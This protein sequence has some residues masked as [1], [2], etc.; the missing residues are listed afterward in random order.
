MRN[1][2]NVIFFIITC[3]LLQA[4]VAGCAMGSASASYRMQTGNNSVDTSSQTQPTANF[5]DTLR[6]KYTRQAI[7]VK[8]KPMITPISNISL[9][10]K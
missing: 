10:G 9:P 2:S 7:R 8:N 3:S 1:I 4:C 6:S 5:S